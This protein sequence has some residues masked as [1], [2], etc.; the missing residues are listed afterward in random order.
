MR[1]GISPLWLGIVFEPPYHCTTQTAATLEMYSIANPRHTTSTTRSARLPLLPLFLLL[2]LLVFALQTYGMNGL[3]MSYYRRQNCDRAFE[4][5]RIGA[6][7]ESSHLFTSHVSVA[8][9]H[10]T[11]HPV[12]SH[13]LRNPLTFA[14]AILFSLLATTSSVPITHPFR[15]PLWPT[16]AHRCVS[17]DSPARLAVCVAVRNACYLYC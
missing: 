10:M 5:C 15:H 7:G 13:A 14:D 16:L 1:L 8:I 4:A 2:V 12:T 11:V 3:W 6:L 9:G 17:T